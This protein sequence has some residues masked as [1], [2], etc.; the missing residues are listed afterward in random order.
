MTTSS[1]TLAILGAA[2]LAALLAAPARA[3]GVTFGFR[4]GQPP[5][6]VSQQQQFFNQS[7]AR[8]TQFFAQPVFPNSGFNQSQPFMVYQPAFVPPSVIRQQTWVSPAVNNYLPPL[9]YYGYQPGFYVAPA[10][11]NNSPA[12]PIAPTVVYS[13]PQPPNSYYQNRPTTFGGPQS[14]RPNMGLLGRW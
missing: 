6:V 7:P 13:S 2:T 8:Q 10:Y 3:D 9:F 1:K 11:Y 5:R 12:Y 4:G 14:A